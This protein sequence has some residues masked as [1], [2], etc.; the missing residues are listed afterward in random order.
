MKS[1]QEILVCILQDC[2]MQC[3]A[4]PSRDLLTITRRT[5]NEGDSFLTITLPSYCTGLEKALDSGRLSPAYFPKFKFRKATCCP[6]FLGGYMERIFGSDGSL[7][8]EPS[9]VCISAIRQICLFAKKLNLPCSA[10]RERAAEES[11]LRCENDLKN[12]VTGI[13]EDVFTNVSRV[14]WSDLVHNDPFGDPYDRFKPKHGPGTTQEGI[15]GNKKFLFSMW[16]SRLEREFPFLEFGI[17]SISNFLNGSSLGESLQGLEVVP[18]HE[19]PVRVVFVPKTQKSPRVIAIEPVCM[20]FIQQAIAS[21]L[22]PRIEQSCAYTSGRVNFTRQD[23]NAKLSLSSSKS[24]VLSTLDMSEASDRVSS[25]LVWRMLSSVPVLRKQI[26]A[27]RS[28]RANLPSGKTI[29]LRKFASM[30]SALCFPVESMAFFIAIVSSRIHSAGVRCSPTSIRKYSDGVYVYGDDL[31]VPAGE[32][33]SICEFLDLLGFKINANKSF[34]TGKFRESCGMDAYDGVDV[35]PVYVR[36]MLPTDRTD[37]HGLASAVALANQFYLIGYWNTARYIRQK[38][39]RLLGDM[40]A[41]TIRSFRYLERVIEGWT[42]LGSGSAGFGWVSFSNGESAN[43]WS[44]RY[45][46][47]KSKRW[48][49]TPVRYRDHLDGDGA[50]LKCFGVIGNSQISPNHLRESVRYGNLALKRR[51]TLV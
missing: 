28:T 49:V 45:Q 35:T 10:R 26:F 30:G 34:W 51:W 16:P 43:G 4:N 27:C 13:A 50:L 19:P 47:F 46:C 23:I 31:I 21:W 9:S 3:G 38:V 37:A 29:P 6:R 48:V 39:E 44:K 15:R 8:E 14:I 32:A 36:S 42:N 7:L 24:G 5:E 41:I 11:F 25:G 1:L 33:P 17:G 22:K 2:S 20:Q 40:P 12:H 18:R